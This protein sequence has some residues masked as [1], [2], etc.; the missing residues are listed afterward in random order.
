MWKYR[1]E[2]EGHKYDVDDYRSPRTAVVPPGEGSRHVRAAG[3]HAAEGKPRPPPSLTTTARS[4]ISAT[5][6]V[7]GRGAGAAG[8]GSSSASPATRATGSR[9][10][11]TAATAALR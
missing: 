2:P 7:T 10:C 9:T 3:R 1:G 11:A 6:A 8:A 4:A 5:A